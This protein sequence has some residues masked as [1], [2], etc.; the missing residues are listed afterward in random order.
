MTCICVRER[1]SHRVSQSF[2]QSSQPNTAVCDSVSIP[3]V[4]LWEEFF[5][6]HREEILFCKHLL[7]HYLLFLMFLIRP[8]EWQCRY[9]YITIK[10]IS[11]L[12]RAF[13]VGFFAFGGLGCS[14]FFEVLGR[15]FFGWFLFGIF[16]FGHDIC[17][18]GIVIRSVLYGTWAMHA[19]ILL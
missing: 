14:F 18:F 17:S 6:L 8:S 2:S 5:R 12:L 13:T 4:T 19:H 7:C 9:T 11:V 15:R 1:V 16:C 3:C 10:F